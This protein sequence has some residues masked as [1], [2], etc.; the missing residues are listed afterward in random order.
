MLDPF[1]SYM[2]IDGFMHLN[3]LMM[4]QAEVSVM[5]DTSPSLQATCSSRVQLECKQADMPSPLAFPN[6]RRLVVNTSGIHRI[7]LCLAVHN[8]C[9]RLYPRIRAEL[10]ATHG[11]MWN[12]S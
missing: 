2:S 5:A 7:L 8:N 1:R 3:F 4:Y 9:P 10:N 12:E 11:G 6:V